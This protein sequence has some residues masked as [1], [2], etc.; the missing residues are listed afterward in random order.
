MGKLFA[1]RVVALLDTVSKGVGALALAVV[2][3]D[4][5]A[6]KAVVVDGLVWALVLGLTALALWG[7]ASWVAVE[8]GLDDC[9]E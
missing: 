1:R 4:G 6:G 5:A 8:A 3:L 2:G 7:V 9:D